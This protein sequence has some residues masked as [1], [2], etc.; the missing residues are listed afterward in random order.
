MPPAAFFHPQNAPKGLCPTPKWGSLERCKDK[1]PSCIKGSLLLR[2]RGAERKEKEGGERDGT[3]GVGGRERRG[4]K[5]GKGQGRGGEDDLCFRLLLGPDMNSDAIYGCLQ[6]FNDFEKHL[7][8]ISRTPHYSMFRFP[9]AFF[10]EQWLATVGTDIG[11]PRYTVNNKPLGYPVHHVCL[12]S[13]AWQS[14]HL[15][16]GLYAHTIQ[17]D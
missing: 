2:G 4:R 11:F 1:P 17:R 16:H 12:P 13:D 14:I 6:I 10:Y 15:D 9:Y 3:R 8:Q 7:I 5:G